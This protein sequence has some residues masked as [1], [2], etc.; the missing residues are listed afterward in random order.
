MR[1]LRSTGT[2]FVLLRDSYP[3]KNCC[4]TFNPLISRSL[5]SNSIV[6]F[7]IRR[8]RSIDAIL[9]VEPIKPMTPIHTSTKT[10]RLVLAGTVLPAAL[11][12]RYGVRMKWRSQC[13]K[14]RLEATNP[15]RPYL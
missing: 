6:T 10:E 7:S 5:E 2:P 15:R 3:V 1:M 11:C 4:Q 12:A 14:T 13:K 9:V 8:A